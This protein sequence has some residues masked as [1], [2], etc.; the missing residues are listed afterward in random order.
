MEFRLNEDQLTAQKW[1]REFAEKEI[2]PVAPEYDESEEF[3]WPVLKKAAEI[4]LYSL[5]F[6]VEMAG[7]DPTG[8]IMPIVLEESCWGCAGISLGIFG[9]GLPLATLAGTGTPDQFLE[10]A[11]R[12]L[13]TS[14]E[15]KIGAFAVTE[16]GAGSDVSAL[17]TTAKRDGD[18]WV[19]NGQKIFITNGGIADVHI[20]VATVDPELGHRGQ[21]AFIVGPDTPGISQGKKERKLGIRASHTA[22]VLLDDCRVPLENVGGGMERLEA[23]LARAREN[24][25]EPSRSSQALKTFELTRP[26][27]AAQALGIARAALEFSVDY[28]KERTTFGR[29][30]IEH[31]GIGFKLADMA[32]EV[33]AARLLTWRAAWMVKNDQ[34]ERAEGSMSKLKASEVAVWVTEQAI[35]VLGGYGYIKDFPVEKWYR[36][37]K[38]YTLFEGTSEI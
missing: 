7:A 12:M 27:V 8:L 20:V 33:D 14:E 6:Y 11:P 4:G 32:M 31:Q 34:L 24:G 23:K 37:A 17:R 26:L 36:D 15:P 35:Q 10:W 3:P 30:I 19:L 29:P 16:S 21:A 28:A 18:E 1:A 9:T 2:R 22:E 13:G 5:E 38:I 25:S